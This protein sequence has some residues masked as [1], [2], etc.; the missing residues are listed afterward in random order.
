MQYKYI[1]TDNIVLIERMREIFRFTPD[2]F[3]GFL[4]IFSPCILNL[5]RGPQVVC[6]TPL[7]HPLTA[8]QPSRTG[9]WR[10]LELGDGMA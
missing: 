7:K 3:N 5:R 10:P 9:T 2:S 4:W 6:L 1:Y 8:M